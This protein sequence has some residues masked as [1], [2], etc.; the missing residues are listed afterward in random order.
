MFVL[1]S[2]SLVCKLY[3]VMCAP[4]FLNILDVYKCSEKFVF[5]NLETSEYI[6]A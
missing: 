4:H 2:P 3:E 5:N 6:E 1:L